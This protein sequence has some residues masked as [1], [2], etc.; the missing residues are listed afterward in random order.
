MARPKNE[1]PKKFT[2]QQY[3]GAK[4]AL[5]IAGKE[6][7]DV[8]GY[9]NF[10]SEVSEFDPAVEED[11]NLILSLVAHVFNL[12]KKYQRELM[13]LGEFLGYRFEETEGA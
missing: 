11:Q 8:G 3:A 10:V 4:D 5:T 9:E 1:L 6:L 12:E 13:P 7:T 2:I